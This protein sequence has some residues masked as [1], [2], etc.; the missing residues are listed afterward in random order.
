MQRKVGIYRLA[1][2]I[3]TIGLVLSQAITGTAAA[4]AMTPFG[5]QRFAHD[6][7]TYVITG[8]SAYYR[9]VWQSAIQAWNKTGAF[10][11]TRSSKRHAQIELT[12][13][14]AQEAA[15]MGQDVGM[16][17]YWSRHNQLIAVVCTLNPTLFRQF[18]YSH[19]DEEH[20][21]EHELGHAMGLNH[22][23]SKHSVMYYR[24]RAVGIQKVDV[25]GVRQRYQTPIG[26]AS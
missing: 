15:K 24:N 12:A 18:D 17:D 2:F 19:A 10:T 23:P 4:A 25:E 22:N 11:F 20:V 9:R 14:T 13:D 16:T 5:Q 3:V 7:A 8:K 6:H 21:A 26:E 1:V